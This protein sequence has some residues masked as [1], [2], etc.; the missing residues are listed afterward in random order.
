M[1]N[2]DGK[3]NIYQK[4]LQAQEAI[5]SIKPDA[6]IESGPSKGHRYATKGQ[7]LATL[8]EPIHKA[9]LVILTSTK[10]LE[11]EIIETADKD[12]VLQKKL[13]ATVTMRFKIV[14]PETGQTEVCESVGIAT[15]NMGMADQT[16]Q[17]AETAAVRIWYSDFFQAPVQESG[18][19]VSGD[20]TEKQKGYIKKLLKEVE[21]NSK[22][23]LRVFGLSG[24]FAGDAD[25][26]KQAMK[27]CWRA[28][29]AN[30]ASDIIKELQAMKEVSE[31]G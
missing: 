8:R 31:Q 28:L 18:N 6:S 29:T 17:K 30:K 22:D 3:K 19:T 9:G 7:I 27:E 15:G 12:G 5:V 2:S 14:D 10:R 25:E 1:E 4:I 26:Y 23:T 20:A 13:I 21:L 16:P 24:T 11:K